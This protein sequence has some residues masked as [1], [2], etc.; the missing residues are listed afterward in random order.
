MLSLNTPGAVVA[1]TAAGHVLLLSVLHDGVHH[2]LIA[3]HARRVLGSE[4]DQIGLH[5]YEPAR[6]AV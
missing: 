1:Y 5:T 4:V 3:A 6:L 2:V